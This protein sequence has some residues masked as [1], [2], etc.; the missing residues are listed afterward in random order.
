MRATPAIP[1]PVVAYVLDFRRD[2]RYGRDT[3]TRAL[4]PAAPRTSGRPRFTLF[5][6]GTYRTQGPLDKAAKKTLNECAGP[7]LRVL[8]RLVRAA[9]CMSFGRFLFVVPCSPV[10]RSLNSC[11]SERFLNLFSFVCVA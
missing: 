10:L 4:L 2:K 1:V 11:A 7:R 3:S 6:T 8:D 9:L 5:T